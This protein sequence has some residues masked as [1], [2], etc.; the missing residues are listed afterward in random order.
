MLGGSR[1]VVTNTDLAG[2]SYMRMLKGKGKEKSSS[3]ESSGSKLKPVPR[4]M[5]LFMTVEAF[6]LRSRARFGLRCWL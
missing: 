5:S 1:G 2:L 6:I 3:G 4:P